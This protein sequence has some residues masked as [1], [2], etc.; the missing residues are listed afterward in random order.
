MTLFWCFYCYLSTDFTHYFGVSIIEFEQVN[1][2]YGRRDCDIFSVSES[3]LDN[4][5]PNNQ[6]EAFFSKMFCLDIETDMKL[7]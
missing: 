7:V 5:F 6:L 2:C 1:D 3:K 4:T